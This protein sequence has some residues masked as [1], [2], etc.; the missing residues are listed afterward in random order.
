M[1]NNERSVS[2]GGPWA[3]PLPS[4]GWLGVLVEPVTRAEWVLVIDCR[5]GQG[6]GAGAAAGGGTSQ[7][8][9]V[10]SSEAVMTVRLS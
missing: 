6:D 7:S 1:R 8:R 5:E 2:L 10:P 4:S 3:G 9:T